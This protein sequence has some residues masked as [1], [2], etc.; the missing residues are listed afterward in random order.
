MIFNSKNGEG[1]MKSQI[2][3]VIAVSVTITLFT[4]C[5]SVANHRVYAQK[6]MEVQ[7]QQQEKS[8]SK[9]DEAMG[10]EIIKKVSENQDNNSKIYY[11]QVSG[12]KGQLLMDYMNQSLKKVIDRY[13]KGETYK[14]VSIDY[15]ITKMDRDILS[16]AFKGT[17]KISGG[18]EINILQSV[19][20][21][22]K[23][24]NLIEFNNLVKA[25]Q[26]SGTEVRAMIN[27][28]AKSM[29]LK[30]GAEFERVSLFFESDNIVFFYMPADDSAT[31]F[32]EISIPKKELEIYT[33]TA[34]GERPAS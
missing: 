14:D 21:D 18:K 24:S 15:K 16:I 27:L 28:K 5:G 29:G 2:A 6:T 17:G 12:Y 4:G 3:L 7:G 11:P 34:F 20:L 31:D 22:I 32:V 10:Y 23:T 19:N 13:G 9:A 30:S 1:I 25:D 33:N 8:T 26:E